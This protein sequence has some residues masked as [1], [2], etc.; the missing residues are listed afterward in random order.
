MDIIEYVPELVRNT[1]RECSRPL[2]ALTDGGGGVSVAS[3]LAD[4]VSWLYKIQ[5]RMAIMPSKE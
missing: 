1:E 5:N 3:L 4:V 2:E